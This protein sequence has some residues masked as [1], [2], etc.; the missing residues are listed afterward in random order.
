VILRCGAESRSISDGNQ[1][2]VK[3]TLKHN[4]IPLTG[5]GVGNKIQEQDVTPCHRKLIKVYYAK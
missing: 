4:S 1:N 2:V 3:A 5:W